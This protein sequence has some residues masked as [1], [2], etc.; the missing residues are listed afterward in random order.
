MDHGCKTTL[1][2]TSHHH[3]FKSFAKDSANTHLELCS[4]EANHDNYAMG[5]VPLI[6]RPMEAKSSNY[7]SG[8]FAMTMV[9][10]TA[11]MGMMA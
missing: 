4:K 11:R 10:A 6:E 7:E 5:V 8:R 3:I 2:I 9:L 1:I